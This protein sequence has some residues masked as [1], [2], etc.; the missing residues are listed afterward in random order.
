MQTYDEQPPVGPPPRYSDSNNNNDGKYSG[1]M[2]VGFSMPLNPIHQNNTE[3]PRTTVAGYTIEQLYCPN[4]H[5]IERE[6]MTSEDRREEA[7]AGI[8]LLIGMVLAGITSIFMQLQNFDKQTTVVITSSVFFISVLITH[9]II[10]CV[11]K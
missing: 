3:E 6:S 7:K 5:P 11:K 4:N 8:K 2:P 1:T 9:V 10:E